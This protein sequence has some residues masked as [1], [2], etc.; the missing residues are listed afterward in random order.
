MDNQLITEEK[1]ETTDSIA[2]ENLG[3]SAV[4]TQKKSNTDTSTQTSMRV[5]KRNG[6]EELVDLNKIFTAC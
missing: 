2:K 3:T 4:K 1:S 6:E 5:I